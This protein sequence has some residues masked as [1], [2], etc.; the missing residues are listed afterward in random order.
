MSFRYTSFA[1]AAFAERFFRQI[2]VG[3]AG[4]R[5]SHDQRRTGQIICLHQRIHAAFEIAIAAKHRRGDQIA[6]GHGIGH[7]LRQRPAV[8]DAR[9]AAVA[10][11]L[12]AECIERIGHAGFFEIVGHHAAARREA[13]LYVRLDFQSLGRGVFRQQPAAS[14]TEGLLV[15]VQLVIAAITTEPCLSFS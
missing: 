8:A 4:Q 15:F 12:E 2:D 5:V 3:R 9:R 6:V 7:R 14:M 10:D 13:G 11:G 1:V